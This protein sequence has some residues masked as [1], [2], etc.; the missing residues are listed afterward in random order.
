M[1]TRLTRH[2]HW[3]A[4]AL[5]IL[6][7]AFYWSL[8][9]TDRYVSEANV[10]LQSARLPQTELS[11]S[12]ILSGGMSGDLLM[13]RDHLLSVDMLKKLD[14]ALDLRAHYSSDAIDW[15]ARLGDDV[16]MEHFHDYYLRRVEVELDE[17]AHV[18]RIKASAYDPETAHAI[19]TMLLEEGEAHMNLL[20]QRLAA[21]QVEFIER[22]VADLRKRLDQALE[23][24]LAYQ[25]EQ[26][27]LSPTATAEGVSSIISALEGELASLEAQ[28]RALG[29]SQ[30]PRAPAMVRLQSQIDALEAQI[31]AERARLAARSGSAL[32]RLAADYET[33]QLQVDFAREMYSSALAALESTRVE[34]A[35]SLQ[36][37]SVLQ[38]PTRPEYATEPARLYNTT[39]FAILALLG[40]LIA[41][42]LA[43]IV[44]DHRD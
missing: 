44:H 28:R 34:A 27:L 7:A 18:L 11:V 35:R 33:L 37:V 17:Y 3:F 1:S 8:I 14:D 23:N 5:A 19:A 38:S 2:P 21:E 12:S 22:Q 24:L 20:G 32:N 4:V 13:L 30:S 41:H 29:K 10:V 16:P 40:G 6:G 42:L 26:G 25:N 43:A 15:F 9:A 31:R 39:V 36:Q